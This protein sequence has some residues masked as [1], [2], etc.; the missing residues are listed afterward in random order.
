MPVLVTDAD[1]PLGTALVQRLL[2]TGG[3]VRAWCSA[4]GDVGRLRGLGAITAS[5]DVDDTGR[6]EA[7]CE[8]VH[9]VVHLGGGLLS[10]S[11]EQV[12][13][14]QQSVVEAAAGAGVRRLVFLSVVGA[15][16]VADD[17]LR[18]AKAV[19]EQLAAEGP[20]PSVAVRVPLVDTAGLRGVLA[21]T[22]MPHDLVGA[23][24]ASVPASAVVELL[25]TIDDLRSRGEAGHATLVAPGR[26]HALGDWPRPADGHV[27]PTYRALAEVPLLVPALAGP[28]VDDDPVPADAWAFTGVDA[29]HG[30]AVDTR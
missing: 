4:R 29:E 28:W 20:V 21:G 11:A 8:Q 22:P 10:R 24:V 3:Q 27:A 16:A 23:A 9:T 7:A 5:G 12:V 30:A 25:A 6:L 2:A 15:S 1:T 13:V 17:P 14:D 18:R 19:A 26:P